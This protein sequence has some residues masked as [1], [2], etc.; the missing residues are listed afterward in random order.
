MSW[1]VCEIIWVRTNAGNICRGFLRVHL[2]LGADAEH[3]GRG[4]RAGLV[5]PLDALQRKP[6]GH[7][8]LQSGCADGVGE[9]VYRTEGGPE[10]PVISRPDLGNLFCKL[11][12]WRSRAI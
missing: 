10:G 1:K 2:F 6:L 5:K 7:R 4:A 9:I 8:A 11:Y 3:G 12:H